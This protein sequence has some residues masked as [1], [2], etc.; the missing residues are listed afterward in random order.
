[1]KKNT[2]LLLLMCFCMS[3]YN[4]AQ[5]LKRKAWFGTQFAPLDEEK[6]ETTGLPTTEGLFV[7]Q[8]V[9]GTGKALNL[10]PNDIVLAIN[11]NK[12]NAMPALSQT[13]ANA[14]EGD[15]AEVVVFRN[16]K[17]QTLK[18][19]F[20]G[21]PIETDENAEVIYDYAD[22]K[23][24]KL[25]VIINKPKKEGKLP[26]VLFIPGYTCSSIDGLP[27]NHPY[28]HVVHDFSK[29][30]YVVLRIEK[31]GLG[32]SQ[33]TPKCEDCTLTDE[34]ENFEKGLLKLQGLPYVDKD[35]IFIFGHS[36]GGVVAPALSAKHQV[37]GVMVYGTTAKS[38]YE[39]QLELNRLQSLLVTPKPEP[40]AYE[41]YCREQAELNYEYFIQKKDLAEIAKNPHKDS[42]LRVGWEYD[43]KGKI[44][45]R[46]AEYWRQIQDLPLLENWKNTKANV[47]V[48]Y[49][50]ADF[51]AFSKPDHEQIV[52]TVNHFRPNTA[53][54]KIF[55]ETDHYLAKTGTQQNAYD[56]FA[57]GKIQE[58]FNAF[59]PEV[60][61]TA[62]EW[63]NGL[64]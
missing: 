5:S 4:F 57:Q 29:A 16:K 63:A 44:Y 52:Y 49:G 24:G 51:Q 25:R 64:K 9:G 55:P 58:L 2:L 42:L 50:G 34:I 45:S 8:V 28:A 15:K 13:L 54:L 21:R 59:D 41:R 40:M 56:M 11:G 53:T 33:N 20:A 23:G 48:L 37:K 31:S 19:S 61:K 7:V 62:V 43:G 27:A 22:Y 39:Y 32:D 6:R 3:Q 30:G 12:I 35:K 47:L 17:K 14:Y 1:M 60:T 38:W 18:G 46:N 10:Q 36:M 26:A